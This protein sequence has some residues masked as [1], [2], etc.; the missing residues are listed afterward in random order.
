MPDN[1][2]LQTRP[3][4]DSA[5]GPQT[6]AQSNPLPVRAS[7]ERVLLGVLLLVVAFLA[8]GGVALHRQQ[9]A[10]VRAD[11]GAQL[12]T[13]GGLK[14]RQVESWRQERLADSLVLGSGPQF[15]AAVAA[16][17]ASRNAAA[18]QPL[19]ARLQRV[20]E[21]YG[22]DDVLL[23]DREGVVHLAA[24]GARAPLEPEARALAEAAIAGGRP[25]FGDFFND[26]AGQPRIDVAAPVAAGELPVAAVLLRIDPARDLYPMLAG[27]P[28]ANSSAETLLL[29]RDDD[30]VVFLH[31]LRHLDGAPL[32]IRK[33]IRKTQYVGTKA[34]LGEVGVVEGLDYRQVR[35]LADLRPIAGSR[36]LMVAKVDQSEILAEATYRGGVVLAATLGATLLAALLFGGLVVL[37][38]QRGYAALYRTERERNAALEEGRLAEQDLALAREDLRRQ[39]ALLSSAQRIGRMGT[40]EYDVRSGNLSWSHETCELFGITPEQF[41]GDIGHFREFVLDE[42]LDG[43]LQAQR[44]AAASG[45][46]FE[47]EYR[48][49]RPDGQ[50]RWMYERGVVEMVGGVEVRKLGMVM[51]VTERKAA[52]RA[53]AREARI[54]EAVSSGDSLESILASI[55]AGLEEDMPGCIAAVLEPRAD[56]RL[57]AATASRL[58]APLL[59]PE[60]V[61]GEPCRKALAAGVPVIIPDT[62]ARPARHDLAALLEQ[63]VRAIWA[64][65]VISGDGSGLAVVALYWPQPRAPQRHAQESLE[66]VARIAA[67]AIDRDRRQAALR[68]SEKRFRRTF[69]DAATG[70]AITDLEGRFVEFNDAYRRMVGRTREELAWLTIEQV[71]HPDDWP[72]NRAVLDDLAH[73]RRKSMVMEKRYLRPDAE[74]VWARVSVSVARRSGGPARFIAVA[75]D[76]TEAK[77]AQAEVEVLLRRER[78]ARA[79]ADAASRY[80]RS[81]FESAPGAYLVLTPGDYRIVAA[82]ET[83]LRLTS[84]TR[85]A[86]TGRGLFEVF[87][88]DPAAPGDGPANMRASFDRVQATGATDVMAVQRYPIPRPPEQGGGFE[89]R[90]WSPANSPVFGPDG[91][92]AF[93]I[94]RI[95]DVT[96]YLR[97]KQDMGEGDEA[98]L[99]LDSRREQMEADIVLR[100]QE[101]RRANEELARNQ[102]LLRVASHVSR[103][104]AWAVDLPGLA[105]HWSDE[106]RALHEFTAGPTPSPEEGLAFYLPESR[107]LIRAAFERCIADG[108]PFDLELRLATTSGRILWVRTIGEA[109]RDAS[110]RIIRVHGAI[111]DISHIKHAA[112]SLRESEERFRIL[113][114]ATRDVIW[115]W[116][117]ATDQLWF[118]EGADQ[119]GKLPE[120]DP[121]GVAWKSRIHEEDRARIV[122]GFNAAVADGAQMW[123]DTYR[124]ARGDGSWAQIHDRAYV[125]RDASGHPTRAVGGMSDV[126]EQ[127]A[128]EDQLRRAQRLEA[129]GQLTGGVA[130]DFNNLLTVILGSAG[131]LAEELREDPRFGPLAEMILGAAGRGSELT[132]R[133]LA[134]ARK[135]PLSPKPVNVRQLVRHVEP[136]LRRAIGESIELE[137]A[138]A[139]GAWTAM[140]D[141]GQLENSLLNLCVNSR[142][143]MPS[144]GRVTVAVR[145][146]TVGP[147][148]AMA[149]RELA[150]GDY[151]EIEVADTGQGIGAAD[152]GRVFEPFFTTKPPGKGTGLG[153]AM[154]YGFVKQSG[155]HVEIDST[156]G[157]GTRVRLLLPRASGAE[158]AAADAAPGVARGGHETILVA[159]DD[160][161]VQQF[162][163]AQLRGLGY[164]VLVASNGREAL[165]ILSRGHGVDLLFTDVVMP[166][167]MSGRDLAIQ[168]RAQRPGL[169]VLYTSGYAEHELVQD[170][171]LEEGLM[172]LLKPY[173]REELARRVR[174]ALGG[175]APAGHPGIG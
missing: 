117:F 136:L 1:A 69:F 104:G 20:R 138:L 150:P 55:A 74:V 113:A 86:I 122:G 92:L 139:P 62:D 73:G 144:G 43:L 107:P 70:L 100:S 112:Q 169:R 128:L 33:T 101:L 125:I 45:G 10:E 124:F 162:A 39:A 48:I 105:M 40:W 7:S 44:K 63:G 6:V 87:P 175:A 134:F 108:T 129:V 32:A 88:D 173:R 5:P 135:Q 132:Q 49:R 153:L 85:A 137:L 131:I 61:A 3:A 90:F 71:T 68:E 126:T 127:R 121:G 16:W 38:R 75:E 157:Q 27:W 2:R 14:A 29:R 159:E 19:V 165:E 31:R 97:Y 164:H 59:E 116:D 99:R 91:S 89:E 154:V 78:A 82:S 60:Q 160:P 172:L 58:P 23:V 170:G 26:A 109:L 24:K 166:G 64:F 142:D 84:T 174:E 52:E 114:R 30:S 98:H 168:A 11:K 65:P 50:V 94:H 151:V 148:A 118:H 130:H 76:I 36:W 143:A 79:E 147:D 103:L 102:A 93:I 81:L 72:A 56:G 51:D 155:G 18:A 4:G 47:A 21:G 53:R 83:Y 106:V 67:I 35:V 66:R 96:D 115:D 25:V 156:V 171:R 158:S 167:G 119:L 54:L 9:V 12:S 57:R 110:G 28:V 77:R 123:S 37:Q 41:R 145:E 8:A 133:L 34:A 161:L 42:D 163:V 141:V 152:L 80:Y 140:V 149:D 146:A 111:Q 17:L 95:E 15:A 22:Y 46:A 120:L 13:I